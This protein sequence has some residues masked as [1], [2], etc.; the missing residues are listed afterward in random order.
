MGTPIVNYHHKFKNAWLRLGPTYE[1]GN[2]LLTRTSLG[3]PTDVAGYTTSN[4]SNE[5]ANP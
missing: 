4:L 2:E 5:E 3:L 1:S